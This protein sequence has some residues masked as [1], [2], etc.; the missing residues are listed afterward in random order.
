MILPFF[1]RRVAAL[2]AAR[3]RALF[4]ASLMTLLLCA[5]GFPAQAREG[6][7]PKTALVLATFGS[8]I[9]Q[10]DDPLRLV[11]ERLAQEL[12]GQSVFVA[13]TSTHVAKTLRGRGQD[14]RSLNQVLA[15]I[16]ASGYDSAVVQS[17]QVVPGKEFDLV[18]TTAALYPSLPKGALRTSV[19]LPLIGSHA[20]AEIVSGVLL[21]SLPKAR[22][23]GDAVVFVGHGAESPLGSLAYPALQSFLQAKDPSAFVG[24]VEGPYTQDAIL[25][26]LRQG[27]KQKRGRV[28]WLAPLLTIVGDHAKNDI[29]GPEKESWKSVFEAAGYTVKLVE[30]GLLEYPGVADL[31]VDHA[32]AAKDMLH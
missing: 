21:A 32:K 31:F 30:R 9:P 3:I 15:D 18:R 16:A 2:S 4:V 19:G 17:L 11:K 12:P 5:P 22:Q 23:A 24:T 25:A 28:V 8:T 10:Q 29:F 27:G 26:S 7:A 14:A 1:P 20:D 6:D 13:Y